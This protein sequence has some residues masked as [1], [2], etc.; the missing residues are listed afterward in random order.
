MSTQ[1]IGFSGEI[2]KIITKYYVLSP[3]SLFLHIVWWRLGILSHNVCK[4]VILN[5]ILNGISFKYIL[6][7][8]K[9]CLF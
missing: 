8:R 2:E 7:I 6:I 5:I 9:K 4:H 3:L 1:K